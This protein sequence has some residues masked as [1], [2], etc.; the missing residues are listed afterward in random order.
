MRLFHDGRRARVALAGSG[1]ISAGLLRVLSSFDDVTVTAVLTGR[2]PGRDHEYPRADL[3]VRG[4]DDLVD[5]CDLVVECSGGVSRAMRVVAAAFTAGLPVVTVNAEFQVTV[6]HLFT[7]RGLLTEAD[8]DQP[9]ALAALAEEITAM[10]FRPV[11]YGN[12]KT[13]LDTNPSTDAMRRQAALHGISRQQVT[14]FTD[15]TKLHVEL[16]LVA[17][18][19]GAT[20]A[21]EGPRGVHGTDLTACCTTLADIAAGIGAPISDYCMPGHTDRHVFITATHPDPAVGELAHYKLGPGPLY[22][23][24]RDRHLGHFEVPRTIRRVLDTGQPLINNGTAPTVSV[25]AVAKSAVPAGTYVASAVGSGL[26]RGVAVPAA[27]HPD[28]LPIGLIEGAV[29]R[30]DIAEGMFVTVDDVDLDDTL[31][32]QLAGHAVG[33]IVR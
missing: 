6:G 15:G 12:I 27:E 3:L 24:T 20:I 19:L 23:F 16:A 14:S 8:G 21:P 5:G 22:T 10:G 30:R 1:Y 11:V 18:G 13:F 17:N 26:F 9:G 32:G 29:L 7:S 28:L 2:D 25:A 4:I 33:G 31:A